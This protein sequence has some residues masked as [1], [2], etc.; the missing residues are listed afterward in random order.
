M[1]LTKSQQKVQDTKAEVKRLWNLMCDLKGIERDSTF[2][3]F[4]PSDPL[5]VEYNNAMHAYQVALHNERKNAARRERHEVLTSMGLKRV[6][7][8]LGG[9]YYE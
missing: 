9:V 1:K 4:A 6:R 8:A 3:V 7:G 5:Q 2:V